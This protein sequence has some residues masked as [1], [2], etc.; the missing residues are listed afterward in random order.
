MELNELINNNNDNNIDRNND[1]NNEITNI[2][3]LLQPYRPEKI[4]FCIDLDNEVSKDFPKKGYKHSKLDYIKQLIQNFIHIKQK[5]STKHEFALIA[6]TETSMW[7]QSFTTDRDVLITNLRRLPAQGNFNTF[8]LTSLFECIKS[9]ILI[10]S[11]DE[12]SKFENNI[13]TF[14]Y[15]C[16]FIY[17]RPKVI[18]SFTDNGLLKDLL[19]GLPYLF[20]DTIYI[21]PKSGFSNKVDK[22]KKYVADISPNDYSFELTN[23]VRNVFYYFGQLISNG[24]QR[25]P[26]DTYKTSLIINNEEECKN[27]DYY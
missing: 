5:M 23:N 20:F 19:L 13:P 25:E 2:K 24:L 10:Y 11:N 22:I 4:I 7:Y 16:I 15:R 26:L 12:L 1:S 17:T 3:S 18:P 6:F 14:I 8:D 27:D 21:H 9:N